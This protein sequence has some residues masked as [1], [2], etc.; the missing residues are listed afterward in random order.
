MKTP[1]ERLA[2]FWTYSSCGPIV[3]SGKK[4]FTNLN[5]S[6]NLGPSYP[7][8]SPIISN[9]ASAAALTF[10][11]ASLQQRNAATLQRGK[12]PITR[13]HQQRG[14]YTGDITV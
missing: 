8:T 11:S 7:D 4:Y 13:L 5:S 14:E 10:A 3:G 1:P 2:S 12:K 6:A 9:E